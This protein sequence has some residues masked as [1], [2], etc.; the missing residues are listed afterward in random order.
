MPDTNNDELVSAIEER[1]PRRD[2]SPSRKPAKARTWKRLA[3]STRWNPAEG[4]R[5]I[6]VYVRRTKQNGAFGEYTLHHIREEDTGAL[7]KVSGTSVNDALE[8][9]ITGQTILIECVGTKV[10]FASD[11]SERVMRLYEAF[12]P[13]ESS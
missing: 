1:F 11:G 5:L 4:D 3:Q 2:G 12:E 6:G 13:D 8:S 7:F 10:F 9:A